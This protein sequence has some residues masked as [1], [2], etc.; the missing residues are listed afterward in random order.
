MNSLPRINPGDRS[1]P[2]ETGHQQIASI[3]ANVATTMEQR[4]LFLPRP[5]A[6]GYSGEMPANITALTDDQLGELLNDISQYASYVEGQYALVTA[7]LQTAE[8]QEIFVRAAV[9]KEIR[10]LERERKLTNPDKDDLMETDSRVL[11]VTKTTLFYYNIKV[12]TKA[13]LEK[14]QRDW[15]TVSRRITQRGQ[16]IDRQ[17]RTMN[18]QHVPLTAGWRSPR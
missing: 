9:R 13:I 12:M 8:K 11:E 2:F 16:E 14:A 15:E 7:E 4:K 18:T 5:P 17:K 1:V 6:S 10:A 3:P